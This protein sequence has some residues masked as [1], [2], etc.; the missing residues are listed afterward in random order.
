M[1]LRAMV[2]AVV[3][4]ASPVLAD[5]FPGSAFK[6]VC[7][8]PEACVACASFDDACIGDAQD[9]GL[10]LSDCK[11]T[12]GTPTS[13]VCPPGHP[14]V[15]SCGCTSSTGSGALAFVFVALALFRRRAC[16]ASR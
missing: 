2:V 3:V 16:S 6:T 11:S 15:A 14:A 8:A 4:V 1:S 12:R 9:A 7:D 13:Y 5:V 10:I